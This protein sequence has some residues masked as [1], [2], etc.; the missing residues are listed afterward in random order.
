MRKSLIC[1]GTGIV[2]VVAI[3]AFGRIGRGQDAK[4]ANKGWVDYDDLKETERLKER[5]GN[6]QVLGAVSDFFDRIYRIRPDYSQC[7]YPL[8]Q[9]SKTFTNLEEAEKWLDKG[10]RKNKLRQYNINIKSLSVHDAADMERSAELRKKLGKR[11][12][13]DRFLAVRKRHPGRAVVVLL[14][15]ELHSLQSKKIEGGGPNDPIVLYL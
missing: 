9:E 11:F 8:Q 6:Y 1:A 15:L 14:D 10:R 7:A 3:L 4:D 5:P 12:M 2:L 13:Q